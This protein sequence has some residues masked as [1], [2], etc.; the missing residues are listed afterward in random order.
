MKKNIGFKVIKQI[1]NILTNENN[2]TDGLIE[3]LSI[4]ELIYFK[5]VLVTSVDVEL[6]FSAYKNTLSSNRRS[7]EF[8]NS[9]KLL[10]VQYNHFLG[11]YGNFNFFK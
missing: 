9:K 3:D 1:L 11:T 7:F 8:E 6:C 10:I 4:E 5:Y 2:A